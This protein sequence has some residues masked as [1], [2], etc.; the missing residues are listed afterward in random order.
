MIINEHKSST[1][2]DTIHNENAKQT[3]KTI[4]TQTL[5]KQAQGIRLKVWLTILWKCNK[6]TYTKNKQTDTEN[7]NHYRKMNLKPGIK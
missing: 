1:E 5:E 7:N 2:N 6:N 4:V 3:N